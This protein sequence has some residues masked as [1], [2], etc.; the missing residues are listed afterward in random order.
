M[1]SVTKSLSGH[2]NITAGTVWG[3]GNPVASEYPRIKPRTLE[4][5]V[6]DWRKTIGCVLSPRDAFELATELET[7]EV[8]IRTAN[9]D[10]HQLAYFLSDCNKITHVRHPGLKDHP[11]SDAVSANFASDFG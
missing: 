11:N 6:R 7:L 1:D 9:S 8:R 5:A 2:G 4:S 10:A 3:R